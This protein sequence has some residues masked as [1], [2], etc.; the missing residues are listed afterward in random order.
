VSRLA[1]AALLAL[2]LAVPGQ[3]PAMPLNDIQLAQASRFTFDS[4]LTVKE[5]LERYSLFS[6]VTWQVL[7]DEKNR[8]VVEARGYF[9][10][11]KIATRTDSATC[12]NAQGVYVGLTDNGPFYIL[13]FRPDFLKQKAAIIYSGVW[14]LH[15]GG[16]LADPD[17][18]WAKALVT[19]ELPSPT[20]LCAMPLS[21]LSPADRLA[22][23]EAPVT[24]PDGDKPVA[25]PR[26]APDPAP[27]PP[28][29]AKS[30]PEA[31]RKS[32]ETPPTPTTTGR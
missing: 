9:D 4:T 5:A 2:A 29:P 10:M 8:K 18:L 16:R 7:F 1:W 31:T 26:E 28:P 25:P 30:A 3:V 15:G 32:Q 24:D 20:P 6:R 22:I 17:M 27:T 11:D 21:E 19:D 23:Q 13:Q 14:G 12:V